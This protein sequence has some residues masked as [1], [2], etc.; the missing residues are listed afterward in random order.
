M[1]LLPF[2]EVP[3]IHRYLLVGGPQDGFEVSLEHDVPH[4]NVARYDGFP[5]SDE[6]NKNI[7]NHGHPYPIDTMFYHYNWSGEIREGARVLVY[8]G[9]DQEITTSVE[10]S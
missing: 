9:I 1:F 10:E 8:S 7:E 5:P 2:G 6:A 3:I 4:I